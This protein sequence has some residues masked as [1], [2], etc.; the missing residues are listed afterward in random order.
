MHLFS[1]LN[2]ILQYLQLRL[3]FMLLM[4]VLTDANEAAYSIEFGSNFHYD[5]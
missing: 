2:L 3:C 1:F 5:R 4:F